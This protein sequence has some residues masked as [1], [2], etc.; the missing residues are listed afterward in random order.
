MKHQKI[1]AIGGGDFRKHK[2]LAI[3]QEI[4]RL[5]EK[6]QPHLLFIPTAS[7]DNEDYT[8]S[9][10]AHFTALG[11]VVKVLNLVKKSPAYNETKLAIEAADI[12]YVGGGNT[13]RMMNKWRRLGID[14]LLAKARERAVLC[15]TSAGSICW[16]KHGNSDSRKDNNPA[17]D[18]IK[19]TALGFLDA[20]HCPHYDTESDRK[21]S[22]KRMMRRYP[23]VAIALTD[24]AALEVVG[25]AYRII[26]SEPSAHAYKVYYKNGSFY[27]EKIEENNNFKPLKELLSR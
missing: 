24:C 11:C 26:T 17:A 1:I 6:K 16:F 18:Y 10:T 4:V 9:I 12:I 27:E 7:N 2:T 19:V 3:D 25:D 20:L 14:N 22:L 5:S 21:N 13:L 23:G 15:G 8:T